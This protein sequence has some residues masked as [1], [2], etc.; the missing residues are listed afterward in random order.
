[1]VR[2]QP[3][4]QLSTITP[5]QGCALDDHAQRRHAAREV[6]SS[7]VPDPQVEERASAVPARS[8]RSGVEPQSGSSVRL[9]SG[10]SPRRDQRCR[11]QCLWTQIRI[12]EIGSLLGLSGCSVDASRDG[13][14][15]LPEET[16]DEIDHQSENEN[17]D[18][19]EDAGDTRV[20][21]TL[22]YGRLNWGDQR[23]PEEENAHEHEERCRIGGESVAAIALFTIQHGRLRPSLDLIVVEVGAFHRL[24]TEQHRD[25]HEEDE[26]QSSEDAGLTALLEKV[27][28]E[29]PVFRNGQVEESEDNL[30]KEE[31]LHRVHAEPV[32][33]VTLAPSHVV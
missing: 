6:G 14:A 1:M 4:G 11:Y 25:D 31:E 2:R 28:G 23:D 5:L 9:R 33:I 16:L 26:D 8:S 20:S 22:V 7:S 18:R 29:R 3:C 19:A 17:A 27:P 15:P 21:E 24:A 10:A 12:L 32:K 30:Q 13:A